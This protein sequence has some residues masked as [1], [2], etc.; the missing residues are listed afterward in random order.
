LGPLKRHLEAAGFAYR[1]IPDLG[2][3]AESRR[4]FRE[5]GDLERFVQEYRAKLER[6]PR[7]FELLRRLV[8]QSPSV[9]MCL[10]RDPLRC[11]R[12]VLAE[13]LEEDGFRVHALL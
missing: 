8:E 12:R 9:V 2:C 1:E 11:H 5:T 13:R 6:E 10:E 7:A 3:S 4:T